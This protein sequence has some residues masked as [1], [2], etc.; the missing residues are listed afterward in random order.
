MGMRYAP[1]TTSRH[2]WLPARR[3]IFSARPEA[4]EHRARANDKTNAHHLQGL[5]PLLMSTQRDCPASPRTS[6]PRC[7]AFT[8]IRGC[9]ASPLPFWNEWNMAITY[10]V[11]A[12]EMPCC[13]CT[14]SSPL[15]LGGPL[16]QP[17]RLRPHKSLDNL[18]TIRQTL[19]SI[20]DRFAHFEA[21]ALDVHVD[22][23]LPAPGSAHPLRRQNPRHQDP[24][25]PHAAPHGSPPPPRYPTQ[26]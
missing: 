14:R 12:P 24:R 21:Q 10:S 13:A 5:S 11:R 15:T 9:G 7:S 17:P 1:N 16:Q 8:C 25:H 6:S 20:A 22:P 4:C 19:A 23:A 2:R 3:C 18:E 26:G